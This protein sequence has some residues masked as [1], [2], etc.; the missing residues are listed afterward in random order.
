MQ[1]H[2]IESLPPPIIFGHRGASKFAPENTLAS[3]DLAFRSG[4]PAVELDAML[5]ADGEVVIIHDHKVDRTTDG[6][7]FVNQLEL[8][9]LKK[10]DAGIKYSPNYRGERIPTLDEVLD[11]ITP[12]RMVNIEMK[13]YHSIYDHLVQKVCEI[14]VTRKKTNSVLFSSFSPGNIIKAKRILPDVPS[15]LIILGGIL[16]N[17]EMSSLLRRI[18]PNLIYP[19]YHLVNQEI[20]EKEHSRHR[21]VNIWTV[22]DQVELKRFYDANVDGVITNDPALAIE[23][24]KAHISN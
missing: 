18:S 21:R 8:T 14:V 20:I 16:G 15:A 2:L 7:G 9:E 19:E 11:L 10:L 1:S 22:D 17:I 24:R 13:N 3:F 5:S 4:A 23:L 12:E 6:R